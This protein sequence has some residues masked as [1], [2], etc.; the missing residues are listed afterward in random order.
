MYQFHAIA[1]LLGSI[2]RL[3]PPS[4]LADYKEDKD[5]TNEKDYLVISK[6]N[7]EM[8]KTILDT[9]DCYLNRQIK[10]AALNLSKAV[11]EARGYKQEWK[12]TGDKNET[13]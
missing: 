6:K 13:V 1:V 8:F 10:F 9:V 2:S 11:A 12:K 4:E 5:I 3:D 7:Y